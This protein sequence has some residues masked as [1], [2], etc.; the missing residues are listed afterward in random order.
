MSRLVVARL[1]QLQRRQ[2]NDHLDKT[3]QTARV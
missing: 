1:Y 2:G 3:Q